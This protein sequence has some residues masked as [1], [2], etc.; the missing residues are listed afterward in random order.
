VRSER[1]CSINVAEATKRDLPASV[2]MILIGGTSHTGK[3]TVG[4]SLAASLGWE[5]R[6]TDTLARHPGRPWGNGKSD[7]PPHVV[8]HYSK[9]TVDE[10]VADVLEHYR[11]NVL[12]QI[13]AL[14]RARES[15]T[16]G[17]VLQGSAVWPEFVAPLLSDRIV[18]VW[19]I[20][21][22]ELLKERMYAESKYEERSA[23]EQ[24]LIGKFLERTLVFNRR[25][26]RAIS[27]YGLL[28]IGIHVSETVDR[29]VR[30]CIGIIARGRSEAR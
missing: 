30:R 11:K 18:A 26:E 23:G 9:L 7:V 8:E 4:N 27:D 2:R 21:S 15:A 1:R 12:P 16:G 25:M 5:C 24:F 20:A 28:S 19:L 17:L 3:T 13:D 22:E 29:I 6:S 10:L 14:V